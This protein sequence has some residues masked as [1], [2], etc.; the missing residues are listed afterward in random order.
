MG[1][2]K[3]GEGVA[4]LT[5]AFLSAGVNSVVATLWRVD[6]AVTATLMERFYR[7]LADGIPV[8]AALRRA[9]LE[10]RADPHTGHP[11]YWAGFVV[12]GAGGVPIQLE[13]RVVWGAIP[14]HWLLLGA[15]VAAYVVWIL[16]RYRKL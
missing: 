10:T 11:F 3:V 12:V 16:F 14:P 1:R 8:A 5:A 4:G 13:S 2:Q 7:G 9:Q 15:V 6:D